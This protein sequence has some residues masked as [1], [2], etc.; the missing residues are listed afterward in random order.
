M[1]QKRLGPTDSESA[2]HAQTD[3]LQHYKPVTAVLS[4][5]LQGKTEG[6]TKNLRTRSSGRIQSRGAS[7][8]VAIF[9]PNTVINHLIPERR[10]I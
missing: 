5:R 3:R 4:R 6:T 10:G 7:H 1:S 9:G 8:S 2:G